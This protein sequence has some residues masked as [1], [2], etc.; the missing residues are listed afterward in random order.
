MIISQ[1]MN[2]ALNEQV[3]NE[4]DSS[5]QYVAI[6]AYFDAES[7]PELA[8]HFYRQAEEE[9]AHAMRFVRYLVDAS[10]SLEIPT[11]DAPQARF[12]S[13]TEAVQ[14]ALDGEIKVTHQINALMDRAIQESDHTTRA[15]LQWFITEQ[16][17]EVTSMEAL[18]KILQRAGEGGLLYV[19][20]YIARGGLRAAAAPAPDAAAGS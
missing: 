9:R 1:E 20:E 7:L 5:M 14:K 15:F 4:F 17:E 2:R 6:G 11:L 18:L 12:T 8:R 16:F 13:A 10:G 3:G 19:E